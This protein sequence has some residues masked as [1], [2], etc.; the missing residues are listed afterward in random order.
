MLSANPDLLEWM[1]APVLDRLA[2]IRRLD[3]WP[4]LSW[5]FATG[6]LIPDLDLLAGKGKGGHFTLWVRVHAADEQRARQAAEPFDWCAEWTTRIVAN[7]LP[8][9]C[10]TRARTLGELGAQD[11]DAVEAAIEAS[12]VLTNVGRAHLIAQHRGLRSLCYQLRLTDSPPVHANTRTIPPTERAAGIGQPEIRRAAERY[13]NTIAA[14]VQPKTVAGRAASLQT[15][16]DWLAAAHPE[17]GSLR[18][19]TRTHLEGFLAFHARRGWRGRVARDRRIS[20]RYHARTVVDLRAFFDDVAAWGWAER[21]NVLLLHRSDI[22]RLPQPL[23]RALPPD[24]DAALT[25]AVAD[26]DDPAARCGIVLLRGTG[27]RLGELHPYIPVIATYHVLSSL[28]ACR[29]KMRPVELG[30]C[31][32]VDSPYR[33]QVYAPGI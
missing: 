2:D 28:H 29:G 12:P 11:L 27:L 15:F 18:H 19:L 14:T 8:F 26:L 10:M 7:A 13:L 32:G 9:T 4:L 24:V 3:G 6:R 23:P 33:P 25:A 21:P 16:A 20:V 30:A 17:V 22:P 5:C 31:K 1:R